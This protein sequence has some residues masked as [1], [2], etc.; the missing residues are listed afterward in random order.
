MSN[1]TGKRRDL[2][3][4]EP[5]AGNSDMESD[6]SDSDEDDEDEEKWNDDEDN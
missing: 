2:V 6:N 3:P 1:I 5:A 4:S